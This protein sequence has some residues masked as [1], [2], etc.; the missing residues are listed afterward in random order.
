[1][2]GTSAVDDRN[3]VGQMENLF[4]MNIRRFFLVLSVPLI[5]GLAGCRS[6]SPRTTAS[7]PFPALT[8]GLASLPVLTQVQ[9]RSISAENL[10]GAK[11]QG[12]MALP[13][14]SEPKPAASARAADDLGQGWKVRPFLRVN[15]GE[16][17]TLMDV[18]GPGVLQHI[19][20]VEGVAIQALGWGEDGKY[21][22][23]S[24]D[25]ASVAYWYQNEPHAPFPALLPPE[26]RGRVK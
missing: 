5:A 2:N 21:K 14:P 15:A 17:V 12:G 7:S 13:N 26:K 25:I 3:R 11:G 23:L 10:T 9:T 20:M 8:G 6:P 4:A 1:M 22:L 18:D 19:W 16:T 24:D